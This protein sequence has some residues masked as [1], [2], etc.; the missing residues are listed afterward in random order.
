M[1]FAALRHLA[2]IMR[3]A[4]AIPHPGQIEFVQGVKPGEK[5]RGDH[6]AFQA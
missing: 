6:Q 2:R 4:K 1:R 5:D 3:Y